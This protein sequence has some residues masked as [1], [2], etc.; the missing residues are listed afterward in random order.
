MDFEAGGS[1]APGSFLSLPVKLQS[2]SGFYAIL[3]LPPQD[4]L[5]TWHLQSEFYSLS[6]TPEEISLVCE[7]RLV[8]AELKPGARWCAFRVAGTL[9]FSLTGILA[10]I[11]N[12]LGQ[13]RI[14]LFA[15]STFDTDYVLVQEENHAEAKD[16]LIR[17]G[18]SFV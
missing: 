16:S 4:P 10:S 14:S 2:L 13:A 18:F 1:L 17:A 12:P 6:K 7:E 15:I 8:P 3:K 11:A 9:D 5:P